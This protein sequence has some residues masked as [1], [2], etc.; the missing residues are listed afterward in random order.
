MPELER[1][2]VRLIGD[3]SS[4]QRMMRD[5]VRVGHQFGSSVRQIGRDVSRL[6]RN[7]TL[8]LTLPIVGLG[9]SALNASIEMESMLI[10]MQALVGSAAKGAEQ[11]EKIKEFSI[12]SPFLLRDLLKVNNTLL[13]FGMSADEAF[14]SM[15]RLSD[16]A[17][18][19]TGNFQRVAIAYGQAAADSRLMGRDI[20]QFINNSIPLMLL[21]ENTTGKT[22]KEIREMAKEGDL[23]F[24]MLREAI[25]ATTEEGGK[26][27]RGTQIL[28]E[29]TRGKLAQ[30]ADNVFLL[31]ASFGDLIK[32]ALI[33]YIDK[34]LEIAE[35]MRHMDRETRLQ[36]ISFAKLLAVIGP[37]VILLGTLVVV[38]G[39][40]VKV[41]AALG[42][43]MLMLS[44]GTTGVLLG[45]GK[46]LGPW[47]TLVTLLIAGAGA[48]R[49]WTGSWKQAEEAALGAADRIVDAFIAA[50]RSISRMFFVTMDFVLHQIFTIQFWKAIDSGIKGAVARF[51]AFFEWLIRKLKALT[52]GT[53]APTFSDVLR[54][55]NQPGAATFDELMLRYREIL[56]EEFGR[57]KPIDFPR[58]GPRER[59]KV[60]DLGMGLPETFV[61]APNLAKGLVGG[62]QD[63]VTKEALKVWKDSRELLRLI[64][65]KEGTLET[66]NLP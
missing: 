20:N 18:L 14:E 36:I 51:N 57:I 45:V 46:L 7:I 29:T 3:G 9:A 12:P 54:Q 21:F 65:E 48:L 26:F 1:L 30:F 5:A 41:V 31:K 49:M 13:G 32:E 55:F 61:P 64:L 43:G 15:T 58:F 47:G 2:I 38:L 34:G 63:S 27:F 24:E 6:G 16:I 17:A 52:T 66:L 50:W 25:V 8:A 22:A 44:K 40:A 59:I 10:T 56:G 4:Y 53:E 39:N 35:T 62:L 37:L 28:A 19:T 60:P 42:S 23:S 33:P 11:F